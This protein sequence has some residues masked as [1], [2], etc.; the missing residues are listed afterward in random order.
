MNIMGSTTN[1]HEDVVSNFNNLHL[2]VPKVNS[3]FEILWH[4]TIL[5]IMLFSVLCIFLTRFIV[6]KDEKVHRSKCCVFRYTFSFSQ[7]E[8]ST[9][10]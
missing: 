4:R 1:L 5:E 3:A 7:I 8:V 9:I 2:S 10:Q 6:R